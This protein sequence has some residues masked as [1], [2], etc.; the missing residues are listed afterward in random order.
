MN[1]A[2]SEAPR[3]CFVSALIVVHLH[4][5]EALHQW[6]HRICT[7]IVVWAGKKVFVLVFYSALVHVVGKDSVVMALKMFGAGVGR[8][9]H[10]VFIFVMLFKLINTV[11]GVAT[12]GANNNSMRVVKMDDHL[13]RACETFGDSLGASAQSPSL[14]SASPCLH[15]V[16][17]FILLGGAGYDERNLFAV[18]GAIVTI[19][20]I[21]ARVQCLH[22]RSQRG[23]R[24][25]LLWVVLVNQ[26]AGALHKE[27]TAERHFERYC[28][29]SKLF[30]DG[31]ERVLSFSPPPHALFLVR[32]GPHEG[33]ACLASLLGKDAWRKLDLGVLFGYV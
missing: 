13:I 2:V 12:S 7:T 6:A 18:V 29:N 17:G 24:R 23:E 21:K 15:Y 25:L 33:E 1:F 30:L 10:F 20:K 8:A 31:W 32:L 9:Y 4:Q 3:E 14:V 22:T 27:L 11:K 28:G 26:E 5:V 19:F 16:V